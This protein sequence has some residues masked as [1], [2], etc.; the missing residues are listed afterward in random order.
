[1]EMGIRAEEKT[2]MMEQPE[3]GGRGEGGE[4]QA[5]KKKNDINIYIISLFGGAEIV[6]I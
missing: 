4:E 3:A 2:P 5:I 6:A 1:M